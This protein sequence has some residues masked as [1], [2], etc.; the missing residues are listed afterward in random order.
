MNVISNGV[1]SPN[2]SAEDSRDDSRDANIAIDRRRRQL[3]AF[4]ASEKAA[5]HEAGHLKL[6][7]DAITDFLEDAA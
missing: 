2:G 5:A 6:S 1:S 7:R 4:R 3:L